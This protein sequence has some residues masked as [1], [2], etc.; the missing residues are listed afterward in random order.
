VNEVEIVVKSNDKTDLSGIGKKLKSS[1]VLSAK[2]AGDGADRAMTA[3]FKEIGDHAAREL[4]DS[5]SSHSAEITE[6]FKRIGD[7]SGK[8][9]STSVETGLKSIG[10]HALDDVESSVKRRFISVGERSGMSL[11]RGLES[12]VKGISTTVGRAVVDAGSKAASFAMKAGSKI[13]ETFSDGIGSALEAAPP[14]VK[15]IVITAIGGAILAAAPA[16]G[17]VAGTAVVLG[18]GA[19]LAGLGLVA[20]HG[21]A[22]VQQEQDKFVSKAKSGMKD[23]SKSFVSVWDTA[24]DVAG[25]TLKTFQPVVKSALDSIAP[26]LKSF[27]GDLGV[28]LQQLAPSI[29]PLTDAFGSLLDS[30]GERLPG[31]FANVNKS[32]TDL[33]NTIKANPDIYADLISNTV[34]MTGYAVGLVSTLAKLYGPIGKTF[35][36]FGDGI[37]FLR[38][39]NHELQVGGGSFRS[40]A[41]QAKGGGVAL[42]ALDK[43]MVTL[44]SATASATDKANALSDAFNR[45]LNPA[46]AVF[47]DTAT[48]KDS[49]AEMG[50][51]LDK[52]KGQINDNSAAARASKQ[53]FGGM[54]DNAKTLAS[55][56]LNSGKNIDQVRAAL[57]PTIAAMYKFAGSNKQAR[58]LVDDFVNSLDGMP[59]N[60]KVGLTLDSQDFFSALHKAQGTKIDPKTGL[61][62]GNNSDYL[63]KWLRANKLRIDPKT[64]LLKGN[65]AD[66][67]NKWLKANHLKIDPKTGIIKG[68]SA[69]FWRTV[70]SIPASVGSR[71]LD[72]FAVMHMSAVQ[73]YTNKRANFNL[74]AS[75]GVVGHA[76]EGGPR[77]NLTMVGEHGP[78]LVSLPSGSS[79]RSNSDTTRMLS[80]GGGGSDRPIIVQLLLDGK[81]LAK[82]MITPMRGEIRDRGGRANNSV[83]RVLGGTI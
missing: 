70:H 68:N 53:A 31:A 60:K 4:G 14:Q 62:K 81:V 56:M 27:I 51:A 34:T 55:D 49:V 21:F 74:R 13:G 61:L 75:G 30:L 9:M 57:N 32:V 11:A 79:V 33:A 82:Q 46:E 36:L 5:V 8:S 10:G 59:A 25:R 44:A 28:S 69:A 50:K 37:S 38:G 43:D 47:K 71:R 22:S 12:K 26:H 72:I 15:A 18:F 35:A 3:K 40:F 63:N 39:T 54:I 6:K 17:A 24:F 76:A 80:G 45:L 20:S 73:A 23:V 78:E 66:Y 2:D 83:Q 29:G 58:A 48:L 41:E 65:N 7:E 64:G 42:S 1:L 67:Y 19:G 16:I 77:S 52:S